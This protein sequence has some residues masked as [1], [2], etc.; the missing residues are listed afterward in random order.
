LLGGKRWPGSGVVFRQLKR[1]S[2][3]SLGLK[4]QDQRQLRQL[5]RALCPAEEIII[6]HLVL[7]ATYIFEYTMSDLIYSQQQPPSKVIQPPKKPKKRTFISDYFSEYAT[8]YSFDAGKETIAQ[9]HELNTNLNWDRARYKEER[10]KLQLALVHQFNQIYGK[11]VNRLAGWQAL[12]RAIKAEKIPSTLAECQEV[13]NHHTS[14]I[15]YSLKRPS[16]LG[17]RTYT[18]EPR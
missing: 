10:D 11:D 18:R 12:L 15:T 9:F 1:P 3:S 4:L 14:C 5:A 17:Y 16:P 8:E 13:S 6:L 2:K 7:Y